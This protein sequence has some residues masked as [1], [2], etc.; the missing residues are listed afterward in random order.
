VQAISIAEQSSNLRMVARTGDSAAGTTGQFLNFVQ[1]VIND[2][3]QVAFFANLSGEGVV[4]NNDS[5]LWT[6]GN[7]TLSLVVREGDQAMGTTGLFTLVAQPFID[8][9]G[10]TSFSAFDSGA[11][12]NGNFVRGFW[13]ETPNGLSAIARFGENAPGT[14][15]QFSAFPLF[16]SNSDAGHLAIVGTITGATISTTNDTGV[17][18]GNDQSFELVA[19][20]GDIAPGTA[21]LFSSFSNAVVDNHGRGAFSATLLGTGANRGIWAVREAAL[22]P[23][24]LAGQIAPGTSSQF[25]S[26][27]GP[28]I[29]SRGDLA[30]LGIVAGADTTSENTTGIWADSAGTLQLVVRRGELAPGT[31]ARF[32]G[33]NQ[34]LINGEG[35]ITFAGTLVG[36]GVNGTNNSGIWSEGETALSLVARRGDQ[37]PGTLAQFA[38]LNDPVANSRGQIAFAANLSGAGVNSGNDR[39]IWATDINGQLQIIVREGDQVNVGDDLLNP[40][41]RTVSTFQFFGNSGGQDGRPN[42]FNDAGQLAFQLNF[43]DGSQA[44][45]I[46]NHVAV[47]EPRGLVLFVLVGVC[48]VFRQRLVVR[49]T[50]KLSI[51]CSANCH[52]VQAAAR[53]YAMTCLA[54]LLLVGVCVATSAACAAQPNIVILYADDM[55]FGDLSANNPDSKIA[56]PHLDKL[57]AEGVNFRDGHS[58]SGICTPSRYALLTG[59]HHWRDF[60]NIVGALGRPVFKP[61]QLTMP[62]M[63]QRQGYATACIGKWHLGWNWDAIR[64]PGSKPNSI[65]PGDF[66]WEQRV[67]GGPLDR[68]FDHYFGDT[69]INFPPYAWI[70][71]DKL[72]DA[73]DTL[74]TTESWQ[75]I[76]EGNWECR[77]GPMVTGWNPYDVL[78]TIT[79][80]SV[81]YVLSRRGNPQPFFLYVPFSSPHAPIIPNDQFDGKSQAGA[82]G[83]FVSQTDEACGRILKAIDDIG[84]SANTIVVFTA[85]NGAENYA[86]ARLKKFGHWSSGPLRGLK[87]SIYEGGHRVPTII[88]WPGV[89]QPGQVSDAL[90]SQT[91]LLATFAAITAYELPREAAED[92]FDFS[93]YLRGEASQGPRH[94]MVHNTNKDL[95]AIRQGDWVLVNVN[96]ADLPADVVKATSQAPSDRKPQPELFNLTGDIAQQNNIASEHPQRVSELQTLLSKLHA[97]GH[98]APRLD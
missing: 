12:F 58:S 35:R 30:F 2:F 21:R 80:R 44:I 60:H 83:D 64:R 94:A 1:P 73:P 85:D 65:E 91:D 4:A 7:S 19:R 84:Q 47:P 96:P 8:N 95:Y 51:A 54:T 59:R 88:R 6:G 67:P 20:E 78:P 36:E 16:P 43:T 87:R 75:P 32:A 71:N 23:V 69:V 79:Q 39:A 17:W 56:T 13:T 49:S 68:G 41:I 26:F 27:L 18:V 86:T 34:P 92:S 74:M 55:G 98:T 14:M 53:K 72:V 63:L 90:F 57:A 11:V 77:P 46:A 22:V 66:L 52:V 42:G 40:D 3:G 93:P 5:G 50:A 24:A 62:G 76:K 37:A 31:T 38:A 15:G 48:L 33:F 89:V 9:R 29:N 28:T 45:F 97:Q 70:E 25:Q 61:E 10:V 82:F 81:D